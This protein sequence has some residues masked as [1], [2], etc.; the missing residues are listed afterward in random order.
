MT[1]KSYFKTEAARNRDNAELFEK[2]VRIAF[3]DY[4]AVIVGHHITFEDTRGAPKDNIATE[5]EIPSADTLLFDHDIMTAVFGD[6]ALTIMQTLATLKPGYREAYVVE[7]MRMYQHP[8]SAHA[9]Q[10]SPADNYSGGLEADGLQFV[11]VG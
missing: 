9:P 1:I 7:Y 6:E 5:N 4:L 2:M 11:G 10:P 3:G 8:K